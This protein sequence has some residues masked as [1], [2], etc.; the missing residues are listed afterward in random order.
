[1][2]IELKNIA[3]FRIFL[4]SKLEDGVEIIYA[5]KS[6]IVVPDQLSFA[7]ARF[8]LR[9][10]R[11]E[12]Y[13]FDIK[14]LINSLRIIKEDEKG[15]SF[16]DSNSNERILNIG[17]FHD[18]RMSA[19]FLEFLLRENHTREQSQ[20][21]V[22]FCEFILEQVEIL[23][24]DLCK[25]PA[26]AI[27]AKKLWTRYEPT[28]IKIPAFLKLSESVKKIVSTPANNKKL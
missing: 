9:T 17:A 15:Y 2:L 18:H 25:T 20:K 11:E 26:G 24:S 1:M 16:L 10:R 21:S 13:M 27:I 5:P 22:E 4:S 6:G 12:E 14:E 7:V 23:L 8:N 19:H 3:S 28:N